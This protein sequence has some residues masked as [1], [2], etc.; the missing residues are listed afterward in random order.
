MLG[1]CGYLFYRYS[2]NP[3]GVTLLDDVSSTLKTAAEMANQTD[4]PFPC[5]NP[6]TGEDYAP[7]IKY[8]ARMT[9]VPALLLAAL[10]RQES[11]FKPGARNSSSGAMGLGQFMPETAKEWFGADWTSTVYNPERAIHTTARYLAWL[12]RQHGTWRFAVAAYNWGT[13]NV[14]RKGLANMPAETR[15]Y[16]SVVYDKW[17][18]SL[19]A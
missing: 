6:A 12:Y 15:N 11:A 13:G 8:S 4:I 5:K 17:A 18:A 2:Q 9:G 3:E 14:S 1:V 7:Q 10:I 16:V 19:P